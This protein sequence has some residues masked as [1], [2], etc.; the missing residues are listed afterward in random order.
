MKKTLSLGFLAALMAVCSAFAG[1]MKNPEAIQ[2][3]MNDN[4]FEYGD[5]D[6]IKRAYCN[7]ANNVQCAIQM[8][9]P[10]NVIRKP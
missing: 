6:I 5:A 9:N 2:W 7:G 1:K 10:Y 4:T 3:L 8:D